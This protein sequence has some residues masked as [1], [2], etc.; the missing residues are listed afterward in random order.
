MKN[1]KVCIQDKPISMDNLKFI[2]EGGEGSVYNMGNGK[3]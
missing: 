3:A 2:E 1:R